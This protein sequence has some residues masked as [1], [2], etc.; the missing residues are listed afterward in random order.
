MLTW[1]ASGLLGHSIRT[2]C[3]WTDKNNEAPFCWIARR[4]LQIYHRLISF[5]SRGSLDSS[6]WRNEAVTLLY[7]F[8]DKMYC[9]CLFKCICIFMCLYMFV[10][11]IHMHVHGS[12]CV[13][14][15]ILLSVCACAC[16]DQELDDMC[17][18]LSL[19]SFMRRG[20]LLNL[21]LTDSA[22][23]AHQQGPAG[24]VWFLP[25][26]CWKCSP[27]CQAQLLF[28]WGFVVTVV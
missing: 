2:S 25:H 5:G 6:L 22:R 26:W 20:L 11:Y 1:T 10:Q 14:V 19:S 18:P 15:C 8:C 16:G 13:H 17:F 23:L 4:C 28:A 12:D 21:E 3:V 27:R 7:A 24:V 9:R